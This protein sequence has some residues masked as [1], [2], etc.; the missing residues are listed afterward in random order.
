MT[1]RAYLLLFVTGLAASSLVSAFQNAPGYMDADYYYAGGARLADGSG[2]SEAFLWN[3]LDDPAGLPHPSHAYWMPLASIIAAVGM[4]L[5]GSISFWAAKLGFIFI[6]AMVSPLTAA[7]AFAISS[8]KDQAVLAGL[9]GAI[10][11]FYLS[12]LGT[13]DTFGIYMCLGALWFLLVVG[14]KPGQPV[15]IPRALSLGIVSG[16]LHLARA[17]G[18]LWIFMAGMAALYQGLRNGVWATQQI[19]QPADLKR[20]RPLLGSLVAMALGYVLIMAP[21]MA[22]NLDAFGTPLSPGGNRMLWLTEYDELFSYPAQL[23]TPERW[24]ASGL[25]A[26]LKARWDAL[27]QNMQTA[28]AVQGEIF[29]VPL[30]LS[31]LWY[32]RKDMRVRLGVLAW[33]LTLI[34][35][36]I[37]F[38]FAGWRGGFFHSGAAFQPLFWSMAPA[39]LDMFIGWGKRFRRWEPILARRVFGAGLVGLA[40]LLSFLIAYRRVMGSS[41]TNPAWDQGWAA[42]TRLE[43]SLQRTGIKPGDVVMVN[44]AP[45]YYAANRRPALTIPN[46]GVETTLTVGKRYGADYLL[47]ESNHPARLSELYEQPVDLPGLSYLTTFEGTHIFLLE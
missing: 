20:L 26:I 11:G 2:F 39:G 36:T 18:I 4:K 28:L 13:T 32:W 1:W 24:L 19:K 41:L 35:M 7:L 9:L 40:I 43:G 46:G 27:K 15:S 12:Y 22:R 23:L 14:P 25:P 8:R 3:Y 6:G 34:V 5:A 31:G 16:L 33:T 44:N 47:L 17:D 42:Y 37:I 29:L 10:S 30:I 45:G 21:W 38:P